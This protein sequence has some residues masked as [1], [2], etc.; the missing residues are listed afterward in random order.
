PLNYGSAELVKNE[1]RSL[2]ILHHSKMNTF[3]FPKSFLNESRSG[4]ISNVKPTN[5]LQLDTLSE[6]HF[7]MFDELYSKTAKW[8]SVSSSDFYKSI[9]QNIC[10]LS[11]A[12]RFDESWN[13][14]RSLKA[15]S[16]NVAEEGKFIP[17][18]M[19]HSDFT[20]WN[21]YASDNKLFVYDWE[22][23]KS[24]T[25]MLFDL[26]H[27]VFQSGVLLKRQDYAEIRSEIDI[28]LSHPICR[29][30]IE[31]Y[32]IDVDLHYRLYL[33]I[34]ISYYMNIY[35][36]QTN[37][38]KQ[39]NWLMSTWKEALQDVMPDTFKTSARK[40]FIKDF[41]EKLS[42][43]SY[44]LLKFQEERMEEIDESSDIDILVLKEDLPAMIKF[45]NDHPFV[46]KIKHYNKSFMTTAEIFFS[47]GS[48]LALDLIHKFQRKSLNFLDSRKVLLNSSAN[49]YGVMV[50]DVRH[51]LEYTFLFY[52]L[53]GSPVPQ[54]YRNYF[55]SRA[56]HTQN[57]LQKFISKRFGL[58]CEKLAE[59]FEFSPVKRKNIV[60]KLNANKI[61]RGFSMV[62]NL[63]NYCLD[64]LVDLTIRKGFVITFSGVD[65]AGK[66]TTIEK[67]R[68]KLSEK[69]RRK[70]VVLRH[71]PSILPILSA[72]KYGKKEAEKRSAETAPRKGNNKSLLQSLF[73][74]SYYYIDYL[75]GQIIIFFKHILRGNIVL[76]DR[77]YF[78]FI[79]DSRRSN[80]DLPKSLVKMLYTFVHK[81]RLNIFLYASPEVILGR[82]E[83]L[84]SSTIVSLTSDYKKLFNSFSKKYSN[85]EFLQIENID[86]EQTVESIIEAF[87][88][89]A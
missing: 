87:S 46:S 33:L 2:E 85:S 28:A 53:N 13:I 81:P 82:K 7:R 71:R 6:V 41:A 51:D 74:F 17:L 15:I 36:N 77:Y 8:V 39:V 31:R 50:P 63:I 64:L 83:E 60:K 23:S 57:K 14:F 34:N 27:F 61:N 32:E 26:F 72:Y 78:D 52:I 24:S 16:D 45:M 73:R 89:A 10:Q 9:R 47:D 75:F 37:I 38:H 67:V 35:E 29:K 40:Q 88:R 18:A 54:K 20:P 43:T 48:F 80:I 49:Q 5:A 4:M 30:M 66:S 59:H 65:G 69:F 12:S 84:D 44:A 86:G 76:Y 62:R 58:P 25:P 79:N 56:A 70:V 55:S 1:L 11:S 21:T 22:F 42:N 3:E 19:S 68:V